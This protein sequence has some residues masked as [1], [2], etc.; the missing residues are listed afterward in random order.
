MYTRCQHCQS[1]QNVSVEQLLGGR[2]VVDCSVCARRFDAL[3]SLVEPDDIVVPDFIAE[4]FL[5]DSTIKNDDSRFWLAG[6][7]LALLILSLQIWYFEKHALMI[8]PQFRLALLFLCDR[9]GCS[10]PHYKNIDELSVSH[11]NLQSISAN[12]YV[13]SAALSNQADFSQDLP[14][15][16]LVL[17]NFN[18]QPL[19]ERIFTGKQYTSAGLLSANST[20]EIRLDIIAPADAAVGGYTFVLL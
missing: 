9:L 15:L 18:A 20:V 17:M 6:A 8:Q 4:D 14:D 2:G 19:A 3:A 11:S 16:K 7:L 13:F 1:V 5:S 10:L 12:R